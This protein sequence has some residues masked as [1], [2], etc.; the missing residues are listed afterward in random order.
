[1][2]EQPRI[3]IEPREWRGWEL[4]HQPSHDGKSDYQ[5]SQEG[6]WVAAATL[7]ELLKKIGESERVT[8]QFTKPLRCLYRDRYGRSGYKVADIFAL[9]DGNFYFRCGGETHHASLREL[10]AAT[11][12]ETEREVSFVLDS[13]RNRKRLEQAGRLEFRAGELEAL[14]R[15]QRN[16]LDPLISVHVRMFGKHHGEEVP[17]VGTQHD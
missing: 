10:E 13:P 16:A 5:A 12:K 8:V 15:A 7:P 11:G 3:V 2:S 17:R 4:K 1:M 9:D 6:R 14:A